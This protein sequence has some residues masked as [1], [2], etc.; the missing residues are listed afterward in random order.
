MITSVQGVMCALW[1]DAMR[2]TK[3]V[4]RSVEVALVKHRY[5]TRLAIRIRCRR[6][7]VSSFMR[8]LRN[9][10]M[11]ARIRRHLIVV[12]QSRVLPFSVPI[13]IDRS[14]AA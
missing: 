13:E 8:F 10:L 4:D 1:V 2:S 9:Q 6:V 7:W 11:P 5:V 12:D 14:K 3:K